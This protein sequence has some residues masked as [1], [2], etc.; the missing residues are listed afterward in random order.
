MIELVAPAGNIDKLTCV[1]Q[2][3]AD[4]AYI[5]LLDFSLRS[6][7]ENFYS[8]EIEQVRRT[9]G[10]KKLYGAANI[11]FHDD[12]LRR[13]ENHLETISRFPLDAFIVSDF[14]AA[15]LL[16]KNFPSL[17][18]HLST[19]ANCINS[20]AAK[21]FRDM[22]FK[23]IVLGRELRLDEIERIKTNVDDLELEVFVH[24][25]MC[26]A[27]SGRC[28][29]SRYMTGRSANQG[30]CAHSCR[31]A[32]RVLEEKERPGETFPIET[33]DD[34]F[35]VLSSKDLCM[36]DHLPELAQVGI[37]AAKIEGRMKSAYYGAVVTRAYRKMID[38]TFSKSVDNI[39]GYRREL[40]KVSR[41]EF[42]TGFYYGDD[43]SQFPT[44]KSYSREYIYLGRIGNC[45]ADS[46]Y[47]INLKNQIKENDVVEYIG[48]DI[49]FITDDRFELFDEH[50]NRVT[51]ADH[52]RVWLLKTEKE[53]APGYLVRKPN[54]ASKRC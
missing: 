9:K 17:P 27:Y 14:G 20:D 11:Y 1:L 42:T 33:G 22:G 26:I 41:R 2:Y 21:Q 50:M 44:E 5:G 28:H 19:Q 51:K 47:E 39:D 13:L 32:Y 12:D 29:L 31:W 48:P 46:V 16:R 40:F 6:R 36:I 3:G 4:A 52:G 8:G 45:V 35:T 15:A 49:L 7:S 18:L 38:A 30:D 25:A 34:F 54:K 23:R 53:I 37:D 24:G 43:E 10:D